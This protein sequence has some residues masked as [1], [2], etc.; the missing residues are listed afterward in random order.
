MSVGTPALSANAAP[1]AGLHCAGHDSPDNTKVE[2]DGS[3]THLDL[4]EG[5]VI[6]VK[7]GTGNTGL[8]IVGA[9]GYDQDELFNKQGKPLGIS[10]YVVYPGEPCAPNPSNPTMCL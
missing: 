3:T 7:A 2:L 9:N 5:T 8:E 6:C 4:A 10:Y 1:A